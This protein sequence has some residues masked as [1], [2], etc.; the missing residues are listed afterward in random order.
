QI[1]QVIES[2]VRGTR[3]GGAPLPAL[4]DVLARQTGEIYG[5]FGGTTPTGANPRTRPPPPL[6]HRGEPAPPQTPPRPRSPG[7]RGVARPGLAAAVALIG[8]LALTR[9]R[10]TPGDGADRPK[11]PAPAAAASLVHAAPAARTVVPTIRGVTDDTITLGM[12]AAFSGGSRELGN[13]M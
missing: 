3:S 1:R 7:P 12:S 9:N 8:V 6:T 5:S 11:P 10:S 13:H 4:D 2:Q